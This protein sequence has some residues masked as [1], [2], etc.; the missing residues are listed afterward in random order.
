M[1]AGPI[2][3][4]SRISRAGCATA[5]SVS[6][7]A[8]ATRIFWPDRPYQADIDILIAGC[9]TNQAAVFA[10]N[11]RAAQVVAIDVSQS[12]IDHEQYLQGQVLAEEP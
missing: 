2:P 7:P 9:G 4:R 3:S 10:Y 5:G 1:T 12:A 8:I 11:N 6:I